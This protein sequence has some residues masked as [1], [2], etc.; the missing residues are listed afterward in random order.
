M[1]IQDPYKNR[2]AKKSATA[3]P[4]GGPPP[5]SRFR[6]AEEME[7]AESSLPED[8]PQ[9]PSRLAPLPAAP[10]TKPHRA[11]FWLS[12]AAMVFALL[13]ALGAWRSALDAREALA[14]ANDI[15]SASDRSALSA[16]RSERTAQTALA[17]QR[18][19]IQ[20]SRLVSYTM[21]AR[22]PRLQRRVFKASD[23][24]FLLNHFRI[25]FPFPAFAMYGVR[26]DYPAIGEPHPTDAAARVVDLSW[27]ALALSSQTLSIPENDYR[28]TLDNPKCRGGIPIVI[29]SQYTAKGI[30][31]NDKSVYWMEFMFPE[32]RHDDWEQVKQGG[33]RDIPVVPSPFIALTFIQRLELTESS[34]EALQKYNFHN[35]KWYH[36]E[37]LEEA[38]LRNKK[39]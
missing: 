39:S 18:S 32:D 26:D 27:W 37:T 9:A 23:P 22:E 14:T 2:P 3:P 25:V 11:S 17:L 12:F 8:L 5:G 38:A 6:M 24:S 30:V 34:K 35:W 1:N 10:A 36:P 33:I 16:A 15:G 21:D 28:K 31:M 20:S 13:A 19:E 29:E 4:P 7:G